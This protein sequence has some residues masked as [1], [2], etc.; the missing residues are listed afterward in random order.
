[1]KRK[2][3][4][5]LF[6][7]LNALAAISSPSIYGAVREPA[8]AGIFYPNNPDE[9]KILVRGHLDNVTNLP[10]ID[11]QLIALI[12][13]HAGLEYSGRIAA[14]GYKLLEE[15]GVNK[16][17]LCSPSHRYRFQGLSVYGPFITWKTPLGDVKCNNTLCDALVSY[18]KYIEIIRQ[19]HEQEHSIEVQLPYLQSV[20][21][22]FELIPVVMGGQDKSTIHLLADALE[23]IQL[24]ERTIMIASS[25]W[26]HYRPA[27]DGWKFDSA[28][29]ACFEEFDPER[30]EKYIELGRV[31]MCGGG[32]AVAVMRAAKAKGADK[33]K[34]LKYGDSGD[35]S[36]DKSNVVGYAAIAIYKSAVSKSSE[37][38]LDPNN[39]EPEKELPHIL[40][41]TDTE[42]AE[43]LKIAR[44]SIDSYLAGGTVP[45]FSVSDNLHKFGAAFVTLE[46][47]EQLRGCIGHTSAIEE[48]YKTVSNCAI[49][50]AV[51]DPR[52]PP[53]R[54][55]EMK[56]IHIEISVLSPMQPVG[57]LDEIIVGRDGLMIFMG[58]NRGL[59][60]PQVAV[61]Y[62]WDR[63]E[64]LRQTCRK[65]GL[66]E[67]SYKSDKAVIYKFQAVIFGE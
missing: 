38:A 55:E 57:S 24:D 34:I 21:D 18:N 44:A 56:L 1:M 16:V 19:A 62:G 32:P 67:D 64:F 9:L 13:P 48:L 12:V 36:G 65:A 51:Q 42:K 39:K 49:Q 22:S 47:G 37:E 15:S 7:S 30:L 8:V 50:A 61:D 23:S 46:K 31:E 41:L 35:I 26:Q 45:D 10:E 28:G 29:L 20:L 43:L 5:L 40:E 66:S 11:G 59:L 54:S 53:V 3:L 25:D 6:L 52:F 60:L 58:Q 33:V 14:Y 27:S 2:I 4:L 63:T 17:I